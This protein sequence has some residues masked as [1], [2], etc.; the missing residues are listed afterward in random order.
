MRPRTEV[1]LAFAA[2]ALLAL[3][4]VALGSRRSRQGDEDPRR[5]T[6]LA[7][8]RGARGFAEALTSLGVRV[9]RERAR[10]ATLV[11]TP[12]AAGRLLAVLDPTYPLDDADAEALA[13]Y[14]GR[15]GDLLLAGRGAAVAMR[16]FGY[17]VRQRADSSIARVPAVGTAGGAVEIGPVLVQG[18]PREPEPGELMLHRCAL[19][20]PATVDT[21]LGTDDGRAV[22]VSLGF[23]HG[24][25]VLLVSDGRLFTNRALRETA[26][27]ELA[28]RLVIG[29]YNAVA[30]DEY[31]HGFGPEGSLRRAVLDWSAGSPW[32]WALWQIVAVALLAL[33]VS[34]VAFGPRR[35]II[36]RHRRSALEHVRAL[37]TALA[38]SRG[39]DVAVRLLVQGLR[40]RLAPGRALRADPAGW[41]ASITPHLR[42]ERARAE[43]GEL[44]R[45]I[46][47][48][49]SAEGVLQAA[50]IVED[51]WQE[52]RP[53]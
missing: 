46:S 3:I 51:L 20:L 44:T 31:H 41:L 30:F 50:N 2:L 28:L 40:R 21:L 7:G 47:R 53:S 36:S 42:S 5:S 43:A 24:G 52:L 49:Q 18:R 19:T 38:A 32:G 6:Y 11:R 45:L 37:A 12:P 25:R 48:P 26:A 9:V 35:S 4:A 23:D 27:G 29:H 10:T 13:D 39:H 8:P 34:G 15:G 33:A 16:C 14:R 1:T 22:A 17:S